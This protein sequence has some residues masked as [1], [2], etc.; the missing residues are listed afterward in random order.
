VKLATIRRFFSDATDLLPL[1]LLFFPTCEK[2]GRPQRFFLRKSRIRLLLS[3]PLSHDLVEGEDDAVPRA[4]ALP[5]SP[6]EGTS[7][8]LLSLFFLRGPVILPRRSCL[9][10]LFFSSSFFRPTSLSLLL[11]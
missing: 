6:P 10:G 1:S 9:V 4:V 8:R 7:R 11:E 3:S 5:L 2:T